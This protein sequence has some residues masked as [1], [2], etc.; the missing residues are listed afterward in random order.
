MNPR[1]CSMPLRHL[2]AAIMLSLYGCAPA[3]AAP[4]P[5]APDSRLETV[6]VSADRA[7]VKAGGEVIATV[8]KGRRFGVIERRGDLIEI[9]VCVGTELRRGTLQ[10]TDVQWL[11]DDDI[12]LAE[13]WLQMGQ[14]LNPHMDVAVYRA[15]LDGLIEQAASV[16]A[17]GHTARQRA[18]LIGEQL[19]VREGFTY[20]GGLS[21]PDS[22][23]DLKQ[24]DCWAYSL[25]YLCIGQR[26]RMPL[27]LVTAPGH[28]FVRYEDRRERFNIEMT[29]NGKLY[30]GEGYL[31]QRLGAHRFSQV[32]GDHLKSL[33][34]PRALGVLFNNW[35]A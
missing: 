1:L 7:P 23:L 33:P 27:C 24:G 6:V 16:A 14:E 30:D 31:R 4:R 21:R 22:L 2:I 29:E 10:A 13:A 15:K 17:R 28:A 9:Q 26:L 11:R 8:E 3:Q 32:G 12:A 19:F 35:G 20:K 34:V 5:S 18:Q 25:L